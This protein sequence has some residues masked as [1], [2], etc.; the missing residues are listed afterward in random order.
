LEVV[1]VHVDGGMREMMTLPKE[2]ADAQ[3]ETEKEL[4]K[5]TGVV[6]K[7]RKNFGGL[8]DS[9]GFTLEDRAYKALPSQ[10]F[11]NSDFIN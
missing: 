1:G 2:L 9:I 11:N 8:S 10:Y 3:K 7:V 4:K 5:L 6:K